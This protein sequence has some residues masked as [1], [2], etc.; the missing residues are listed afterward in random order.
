AEPWLVTAG[1]RATRVEVE[2][3]RA[4]LL[5]IV[6]AMR[7]MTVRQV[8]YQATVRA[9]VEK[10]EGG[11]DKVNSALCVMRRAEELPYEWLVDNTRQVHKPWTVDSVREALADAAPNYRKSLWSGA[12]C[13]V[14]I[15]IQ[16]DAFSRAVTPLTAAYER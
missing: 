15:W 13:R 8:F 3:R 12:D 4:S 16:K 2:R 9:I 11:Y 1:R 14:Q 6:E 10:T 7:P 5:A